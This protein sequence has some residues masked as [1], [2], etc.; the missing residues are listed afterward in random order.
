MQLTTDQ[1]EPLLY[2]IEESAYVLA[3][4]PPTVY[5]LIKSGGLKTIRP[6]PGCVRISR[7]E[8]VQFVASCQTQRG[9]E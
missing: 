6:T 3:L 1:P 5:R 9:N 4:S 7:A 2:T 8:L